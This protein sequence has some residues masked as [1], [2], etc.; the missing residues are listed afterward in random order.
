MKREEWSTGEMENRY[1]SMRPEIYNER[2]KR[3]NTPSLHYS[4]APYFNL[5][6]FD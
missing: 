4:M 3:G 2:N 6:P 1:F 5:L